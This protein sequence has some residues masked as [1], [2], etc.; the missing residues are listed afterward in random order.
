M[1]HRKLFREILRLKSRMEHA[2]GADRL[3][4]VRHIQRLEQR[5][6]A[7]ADRHPMREGESEG[8]WARVKGNL[9]RI[10]DEL[11]SGFKP[12]AGPPRHQRDPGT[13]G[14]KGRPDIAEG[15]GAP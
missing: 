2:A 10:A 3:R 15:D 11:N 12:A 9:D 1:E 4:D 5:R 8:F 7:L 13:A 14:P 6:R